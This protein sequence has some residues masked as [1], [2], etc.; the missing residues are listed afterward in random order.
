MQLPAL[1]LKLIMADRRWHLLTYF[2]HTHHFKLTVTLVVLPVLPKLIQSRGY[3]NLPAIPNAWQSGHFKGLR[4]RGGAE[5][6]LT[7]SDRHIISVTLRS[8]TDHNYKIKVPNGVKSIRHKKRVI[9]IENG[10]IS[11]SLKSGDSAKL[12]FTYSSR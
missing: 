11:I 5:V 2:V 3:I 1:P 12:E 9:P 4:V 7:W 10:F 8:T 6:D